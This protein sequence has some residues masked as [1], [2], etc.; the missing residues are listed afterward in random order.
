MKEMEENIC[1]LLAVFRREMGRMEQFFFLRSI[2]EEYLAKRQKKV[3][4]NSEKA[5]IE[6]QG[7]DLGRYCLHIG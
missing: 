6:C 2:G 3:F 5:Y 1:N 4:E 7:L